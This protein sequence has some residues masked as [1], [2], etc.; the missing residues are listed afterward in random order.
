MVEFRS[1]VFH[2]QFCEI[3]HRVTCPHTLEQNGLIEC[4]YRQIVEL[5]LTLLAQASLPLTFYNVIDKSSF[6]PT[7]IHAAMRCPKWQEAIHDE[8]TSLHK[9]HTWSLVSLLEN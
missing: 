5:G 7:N 9:N 8:L 3:Q 2:L 1:L 6:L 4:R